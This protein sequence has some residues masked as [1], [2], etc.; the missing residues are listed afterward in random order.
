MKV[1]INTVAEERKLEGSQFYFQAGSGTYSLMRINSNNCYLMDIKDYCAFE[2][3]SSMFIIVRTN[4]SEYMMYR[5]DD[6]ASRPEKIV[7]IKP[8]GSKK[9]LPSEFSLEVNIGDDYFDFLPNLKY[10]QKSVSTTNTLSMGTKEYSDDEISICIGNK[11]VFS[12]FTMKIKD[13][14]IRYVL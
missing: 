1:L 7:V 6:D 4:S 2:H 13:R 5:L 12:S 10:E 8:G 14:I 9:I 11:E 3:K